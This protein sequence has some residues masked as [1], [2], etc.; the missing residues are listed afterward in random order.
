MALL[1]DTSVIESVSDRLSLE[2]HL[3]NKL[4]AKC[5]L[6]GDLTTLS[7]NSRRSEAYKMFKSYP[8]EALAFSVFEPDRR[9][10]CAEKIKLY[11]TDLRSTQPLINGTDLIQ[12][13]LK[14]GPHFAAMLWK[15]FA[16]QLDGKVQTKREAYQIIGLIDETRAG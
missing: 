11:L 12:L 7:I 4:I 16:A 13:G 9:H 14:P 6:D 2:S 10:W 8:I 1:N 5:R 15:M 3:V